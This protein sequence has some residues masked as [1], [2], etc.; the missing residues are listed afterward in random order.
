MNCSGSVHESSRWTASL[1]KRG[2]FF[3]RGAKSAVLLID[4]ERAR[5]VQAAAGDAQSVARDGS[6]AL[7][8]GDGAHV[9]QI[10]RR[11]V[12]LGTVE[13]GADKDCAVVFGGGFY[14]IERCR[15]AGVEARGNIGENHPVA[16]GDEGQLK[17]FVCHMF[18]LYHVRKKINSSG[19]N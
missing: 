14:S 3:Y 18:Y 10:L 4:R 1:E 9:V 6:H 13:L 11:D 2:H 15:A 12:G 8:A 19:T 16:Q 17:S 7:Y 5:T